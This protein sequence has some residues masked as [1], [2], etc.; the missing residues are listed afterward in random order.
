MKSYAAGGVAGRL[1]SRAVLDP[2][3]RQTL[4]PPMFATAPEMPWPGR[5]R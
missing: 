3:L 2:T 5:D 4:A 1:V